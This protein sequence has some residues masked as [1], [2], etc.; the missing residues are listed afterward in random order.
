MS[1]AYTA[2]ADQVLGEPL[3]TGMGLRVPAPDPRKCHPPVNHRQFAVPVAAAGSATA[4]PP[5]PVPPVVGPDGLCDFDE[6]GILEVSELHYAVSTNISR[7]SD[8]TLLQ[9]RASIAEMINTIPPACISQYT[10]LEFD[11]YLA[12]DQGCKTL[13]GKE[14]PSRKV[15]AKA[16][17]HGSLH[18]GCCLVSSSLVSWHIFS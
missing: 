14:S 18:S 8:R 7:V 6:M 1:I 16:E 3:P 2:A 5:G 11:S 13:L 4:P 15:Q 12:V 9:M 10:P 17:R